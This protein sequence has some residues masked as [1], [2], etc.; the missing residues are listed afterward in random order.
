MSE[1]VKTTVARVEDSVVSNIKP[2]VPERRLPGGW[3]KGISGNP[4]GKKP[5][6]K[7]KLTLYRE[8]V[9]MK[10]EKKLLDNLPQVLDVIIEKAKQGDMVATKLYLE[11]V[12]AAKRV[13]DEQEEKGSTTINIVVEGARASKIMGKTIEAEFEEINDIDIEGEDED[14]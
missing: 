6:T 8:A 11:R 9:L 14:E 3:K 1:E 12:M 7:N 5:G 2:R 10:Q 13:A 4:Q